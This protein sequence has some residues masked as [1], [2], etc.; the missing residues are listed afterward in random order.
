METRQVLDGDRVHA[1]GMP[2]GP[3]HRDDKRVRGADRAEKRV[4]GD[5]GAGGEERAG[6]EHDDGNSASQPH[7]ILQYGVRRGAV[8]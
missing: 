6:G 3:A 7:H 5:T 1:W 2:F 4:V 8:F